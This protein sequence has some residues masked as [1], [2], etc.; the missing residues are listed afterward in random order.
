M[1]PASTWPRID[2]IVFQWC[3]DL[4]LCDVRL[5]L[6]VAV[7]TVVSDRFRLIIIIIIIRNVPENVGVLVLIG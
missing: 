3:L 1:L 5:S 7:D 4:H 2:C 6:A